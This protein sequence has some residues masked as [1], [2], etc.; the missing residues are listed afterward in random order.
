MTLGRLLAAAALLAGAAIVVAEVAR[1]AEMKPASAGA[2]VGQAPVPV[3]VPGEK[4]LRYHRTGNIIFAA[5]TLWALAVP[6]A[7]AFSGFAA[8]LRD[9]VCRVARGH[10]L[11]T[12]TLYGVAWSA[13]VALANLPLAYYAGFVR[14]HAYGLS[15]QTLSKWAKDE[16]TGIAISCV[17][18]ALVVWIPYLLIRRSPRRWWLWT[19]LASLPLTA[20]L[21]V[22]APVW[23][24]P[25]FNHFGPLKDKSLKREL[26]ELASRAG[27]EGSRV[28]EV[29][30]SED[31]KTV[32]AYV[33]GFA[34][35][36]RIV[37]WDT[38]IAKLSRDELRSVMAHEMGHYVLGHVARSVIL[39]PPCIT[40]GL[41][42]S[43]RLA[44]RLI[45]RWSARLRFANLADVA[46]LPLLLFIFT[47]GS[48][49]VSPAIL[50]YS[51]HVEHEADVF[52]LELTGDGNAAARAFVRLHDENLGVA[53]PSAFYRMF[54]ASHPSLGDRIDFC[55]GWDGMNKQSS[56]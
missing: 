10:W 17:L 21:L 48:V 11:A 7:A 8:R 13:I 3:P 42:V 33:T 24:D 54:R 20:L 15:T 53:R 30:K 5:A 43:D 52:G 9:A 41:F 27:I 40:L 31:T 23:I 18:V 34:T 14:Q 4:A 29:A 49:A 35:T 51:R 12:V 39:V 28:F 1:A 36:K 16:A 44:R 38:I 25:L 32:N 56:P 46:S 26:L 19:G 47:L 45:A 37:L 55:N 50:A 2:Q 22:I 6:F